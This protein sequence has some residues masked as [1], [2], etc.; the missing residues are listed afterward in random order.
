MTLT[1]KTPLRAKP[2]AK[3]NRFEREVVDILHASGWPHARRNF[4]SG[5]AGGGDIIDG[6]TDVSIECKHAEACRIW[7]WLAQCEADA[8]PTDIPLLIFRRNRSVPYACLPLD[9][10]LALLKLR[11]SS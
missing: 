6:P 9:E 10:L 8:R 1:R 4:W 3:G 11:E 5:G 7:D 2:K